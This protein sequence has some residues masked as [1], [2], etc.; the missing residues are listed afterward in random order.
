[1]IGKWPIPYLEKGKEIA[2]SRYKT[3]YGM[4]VH[5]HL[6][7]E[8]EYLFSGKCNHFLKNDS[9]EVTRGDIVF[10]KPESRHKFYVSDEAEIFKIKISSNIIPQIY[11]QNADEFDSVNIIHISS[12]EI[13][14]IENILLVLEKELIVEDQCFSEM[15]TGYLQILFTLLLRSNRANKID[16]Q[17]KISMDFKTIVGYIEKNLC[18]VTPSNLAAY[19][20]YN[21]PYFSKL[22]KNHMGKNL[23][24][25]INTVKTEAAAKML[26]ESN[27]SIENI[28]YCAGYN[29]KSYFY[30]MFKKYYGVTPEEYRIESG[31]IK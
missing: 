3:S 6:Y 24:E 29:S 19:F 7:F 31:K 30:R 14:P 20:G 13:K 2:I 17:K 15:V 10:F 12:N 21:F 25:Y 4:S 1:M 22:F 8:I 16:I 11:K 26:I 18:T 9:F 23:S 27:K 28:G 5:T